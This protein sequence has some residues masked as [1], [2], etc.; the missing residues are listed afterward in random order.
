VVDNEEADREL[1]IHL[2]EPLGFELRQASSGHDALD[3]LA[4]G[5]RPDVIL[6]DL[7]MPGIDGWETL[8]RVRHMKLPALHCAI[9]SANAFD[10]GL[11]NDVAIRPEDFILK[12]VRHSELLDWLERQLGLVWNEGPAT[13]P[14]RPQAPA[15]SAPANLSF[16]DAAALSALEQGVTLG[17]YR[18]I[19]N[20]LA[21]IERTQ[22][23]HAAFVQSM[24]ELAGQFQFD[25]MSQILQQARHASRSA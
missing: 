13:A 22:P 4:A 17:Y 7:A 5:Y 20:T 16:P 8:R 24:R 18:G 14:L 21:E 25:A 15:A 6:M 2:L 23:G 19:L 11:D 1:L 12:P 3:L 10:K 9:V